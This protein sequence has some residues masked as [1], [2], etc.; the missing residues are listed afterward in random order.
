[1][2]NIFFTI[3]C[4]LVL[5][6][7]CI[8]ITEYGWMPDTDALHQLTQNV[9]T[10]ADVLRVLGPPIGYGMVRL[11]DVSNPGVSWYYE[12]SKIYGGE[13]IDLKIDLNMELAM[14]W[15]FFDGEIYKGHLWYSSITEPEVKQ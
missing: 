1:M 10:K 13:K 12:Y 6:T 7:S 8:P 2:K 4:L 5:L 14:L 11:P 3:L 15:V 9:S